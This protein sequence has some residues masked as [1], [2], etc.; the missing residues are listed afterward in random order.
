MLGWP[1]VVAVANACI[2][3][4]V[5]MVPSMLGFSF[6]VRMGGRSGRHML[7]QSPCLLARSC[8]HVCALA[9]I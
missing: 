2:T 6:L 1:V 8:P 4:A 3:W 5:A 9:A 7:Q